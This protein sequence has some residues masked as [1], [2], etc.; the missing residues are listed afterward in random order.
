MHHQERKKVLPLTYDLP[1][2]ERHFMISELL[3]VRNYV[4]LRINEIINKI[5]NILKMFTMC[6]EFVLI[7]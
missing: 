6:W 3:K 1:S 7:N 5:A 2:S 4:P